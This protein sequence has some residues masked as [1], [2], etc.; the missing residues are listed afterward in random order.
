MQA[1]CPICKG[2]ADTI[3]HLLFDRSV[4]MEVWTLLGL[5]EVI[6][7]SCHVD[8]A[9]EAILEYLRCIPMKRFV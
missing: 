6:V 1:Q 2:D 4:A 8:R 7:R 9:G 5:D 3:K